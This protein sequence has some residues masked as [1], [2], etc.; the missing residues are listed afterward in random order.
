MSRDLRR[1]PVMSEL[2]YPF[3]VLDVDGTLTFAYDD[4]HPAVRDPIR[5]YRRRGGTVALLSGRLPAGM[6]E[7]VRRLGEAG[8]A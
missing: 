1:E 2:K 6:R 5:E 3:C 4:F 8:Q 7:A